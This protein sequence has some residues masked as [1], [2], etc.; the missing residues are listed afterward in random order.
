MGVWDSTIG[1]VGE[2]L[3]SVFGDKRRTLIIMMWQC[4]RRW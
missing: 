4:L 3:S 1:C 2:A